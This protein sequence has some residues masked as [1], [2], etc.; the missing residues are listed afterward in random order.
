MTQEIE[1]ETRR[2]AQIQPHARTLLER[3]RKLEAMP[4]TDLAA[5]VADGLARLRL[6]HGLETRDADP[7]RALLGALPR[8]EIARRSTDLA[9]ELDVARQTVVDRE[10]AAAEVDR[11]SESLKEALRE[12]SADLAAALARAGVVVSA[13]RELEAARAATETAK[14]E[15][16]AVREASRA[17][18]EATRASGETLRAELETLHAEFATLQASRETLRTELET[19]R[20]EF[21]TRSAE[22]EKQVAS[23]QAE[24]ETERAGRGLLRDELDVLGSERESLQAELA[25][26]RRGLADAELE[27]TRLAAELARALEE[28]R[29]HSSALE[30]TRRSAVVADAQ[31]EQDRAST[32][33][34][35][36]QLRDQ[37]AQRGLDLEIARSALTAAGERELAR[38]RLA[39]LERSIASERLVELEAEI[40]LVRREGDL[41]GDELR[42][43]QVESEARGADHRSAIAAC[44][45]RL[46]ES[47]RDAET[48]RRELE[49]RRR[50]MDA[51]RESSNGLRWKLLGGD[52]VG[53]IARWNREGTS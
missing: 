14:E 22:S 27:H 4:L 43:L 1:V 16:H 9:A 49:W 25:A 29:G 28:A 51:L 19:V 32:N 20:A 13:R 53:R 44:E 37:N 48:A 31:R 24:L 33:Q 5:R 47:G 2:G 15:L 39:E 7:V 46:A 26:A 23:V 17:E 40:A 3:A 30:E 34:D 38:E 11:R 52:A 8:T 42:R 36:A 10:R 35:L 12:R 41:S 45:R 21:D 50:E 6:A 18:L